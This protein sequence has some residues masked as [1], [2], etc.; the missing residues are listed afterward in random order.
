MVLPQVT[1]I[2]TFSGNAKLC[3]IPDEKSGKDFLVDTG[4]TLSLIHFHS[5][6]A[7]TGPQLQAVNK[8][9]IKTWNFVNT[10]VKFNGWEY[11]FTFLRADVPFPIV[12]LDFLRFF[13]MQ[14]NPSSPANLIAPSE[15][16]Q[17]GGTAS[18]GDLESLHSCFSAQK[19]VQV[20][21]LKA[22]AGAR[23]I[24][25][26]IMKMLQEE[27]PQ[28]LRPSMAAPQPTHGVVHHILTEDR[29]V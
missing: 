27:F 23:P 25:P 8:Q 11:T 26:R 2:H 21:Q 18:S 17:E 14:V 24:P 12:G 15:R 4:A 13:G 9:S 1:T 10:V 5:A 22:A 19:E 3:F 29:Q 28:L 6:A 20:P 7:A 16:T